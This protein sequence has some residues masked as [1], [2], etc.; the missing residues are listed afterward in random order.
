[1]FYE[2]KCTFRNASYYTSIH[3]CYTFDYVIPLDGKMNAF[4]SLEST[5]IHIQTSRRHNKLVGYN[6]IIVEVLIVY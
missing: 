1:M 4:C 5:V 2:C 3:A 6:T